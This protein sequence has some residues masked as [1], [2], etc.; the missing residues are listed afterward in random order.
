M[1]A[2]PESLDAWRAA[3]GQRRFQG[4]V[5]LSELTRLRASL[6][7]DRGAVRFDL[8]FGRDEYDV[9]FLDVDLE[10]VLPLTCQ[11]SLEA[12]DLPVKLH[13][14]MG[15]M[16][17]ETDEAGLP[18]GY[19]PLLVGPAGLNLADVI[20]D[21]LIMALPVV[22]IKPGSEDAVQ[23]WAEPADAATPST[24]PNPFAALARLKK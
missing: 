17:R 19:E 15:L 13:Q 2:L 21:E 5:R 18:A 23:A 1:S 14:R 16:S 4:T 9:A 24:R 6:A 11:R 12:F 22:P 8:A 7:D 10:A 20:E 3:G